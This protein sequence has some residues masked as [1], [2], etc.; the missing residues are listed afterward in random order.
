LLPCVAGQRAVRKPGRPDASPCPL[1]HDLPGV[2]ARE[3]AVVARATACPRAA[4]GRTERLQRA[5]EAQLFR[6]LRRQRKSDIMRAIALIKRTRDA[7]R[8][9][10]G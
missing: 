2:D 3:G 9:R 10:I 4:A 7:E 8:R 5:G 6:G 1:R